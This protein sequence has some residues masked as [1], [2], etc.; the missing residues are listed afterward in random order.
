MYI[1]ES[2]PE[3]TDKKDTMRKSD[4]GCRDLLYQMSEGS[5]KPLQPN[6]G[7]GTDHE[8]RGRADKPEIRPTVYGWNLRRDKGSSL[9]WKRFLA[10]ACSQSQ[11]LTYVVILTQHGHASRIYRIRGGTKWVTEDVTLKK[12]FEWETSLFRGQGS[13]VLD[14]WPPEP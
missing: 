10:R 4:R 3:R 11:G 8:I 6:Q 2:F 7:L 9:Q 5:V 13:L 14:F 12:D 1:G